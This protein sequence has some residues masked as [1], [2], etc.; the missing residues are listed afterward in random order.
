[1]AGVIV[2]WITPPYM[3]CSVLVLFSSGLPQTRMVGTPGAQ[4]MGVRGTQGIGVS[5]PRAA[6]GGAGPP[7]GGT[8]RNKTGGVSMFLIKLDLI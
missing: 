2:I 1:M 6:A 7:G 5:A 4:G 8:G 3:H